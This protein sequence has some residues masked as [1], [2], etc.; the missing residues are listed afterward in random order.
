M[1]QEVWAHDD[2][3]KSAPKDIHTLQ[4]TRQLKTTGMYSLTVLEAR[5]LRS[6]SQQDC[7]PPEVLGRI[8]FRLL[9]VSGGNHQSLVC[10]GL[11]TQPVLLSI[12]TR[13]CLYM[14]FSSCKDTSHVGLYSTLIILTWLHLQR[15]CFL[16]LSHPQ[17]PGV[18]TSTCIWGTQLNP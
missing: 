16:M 11:Q 13:Y 12:I 15:P 6:K 10:V 8:L 9:L 17:V 14:T 1:L 5:S 7:A 4:Q 18:R 2:R 3:L